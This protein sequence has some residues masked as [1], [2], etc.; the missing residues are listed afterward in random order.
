MMV[1]DGSDR[2]EAGGGGDEG[3]KGG[4]LRMVTAIAGAKDSD[5]GNKGRGMAV[6][7]EIEREKAIKEGEEREHGEKERGSL[8]FDL[9]F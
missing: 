5:N 3:K 9:W 7:G 8:S 4:I 6:M 2:E 1:A